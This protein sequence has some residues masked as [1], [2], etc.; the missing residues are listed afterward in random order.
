VNM[1]KLVEDNKHLLTLMLN[2]H[3]FQAKA[4]LYT[5]SPKQVLFFS[6]IAHN[7][8]SLPLSTKAKT[9]VLKRKNLLKKLCDN[10]ISLTRK[11]LLIEKHSNQVLQVLVAV[12]KSLTNL[13]L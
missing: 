5:L 13:L 6:E 4:L 2:T 3:K 1:S 11:R 9:I 7:L 10:K 12:K 8:I